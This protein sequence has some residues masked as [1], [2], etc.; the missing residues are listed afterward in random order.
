MEWFRAVT[1]QT[2]NEEPARLAGRV[3]ARK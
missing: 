3:Q 2:A 1:A